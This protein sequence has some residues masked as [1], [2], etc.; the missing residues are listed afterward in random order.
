MANGDGV[1]MLAPEVRGYVGLAFAVKL[2]EGDSRTSPFD[3][4]LSQRCDT[5]RVLC[6]VV[7]HLTEQHDMVALHRLHQRGGIRVDLARRRSGYNTRTKS[8]ASALTRDAD[9]LR[10]GGV[11]REHGNRFQRTTPKS[12][13][14]TLRR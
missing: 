2:F 10:L 6:C 14:E 5:Q 7:V 3:Y 1:R 12:P 4:E 8:D 11:T 13:C 9:E